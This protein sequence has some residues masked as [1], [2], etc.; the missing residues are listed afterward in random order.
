[1]AM[2]TIA[3]PMG[4]TLSRL[5]LLIKRP[6]WG[7]I[8][9]ILRLVFL[10][11]GAFFGF[12]TARILLW[13]VHSVEEF[14]VDHYL[15]VGA[16][17][18]AITSSVFFGPVLR[19]GKW[20]SGAGLA[21]AW[22]FT[23]V[24]CLSGSVGRSDELANERNA[25]A[26]Q[27]NRDRDRA[28]RNRDEAKQRYDTALAAET[29]DCSGGAGPKCIGK[30]AVTQD[31]RTDYEVSETLLQHV[32]PEQRENGRLKRL[33]QVISICSRLDEAE[34]E[35]RLVIIWP[36]LPP[37]SCELLT[38]VFMHL[39]LTFGHSRRPKAQFSAPL[40]VAG[41][42]AD[43]VQATPIEAAQVLKEWKPMSVMRARELAKQAQAEA[44]FEALRQRSPVCND[45]LAK[46]LNINK[47]ECSRRV[48]ALHDVGLINRQRS[49]R[50]V[51]ITLRPLLTV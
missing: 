38:M 31:R 22:V 3:R 8:G 32:K 20:L 2:T 50:Y 35:R 23:T 14:T 15:T 45:E 37:L 43:T 47:G 4:A 39:G 36:F 24:I 25:I 46:H 21:I 30:R 1:M 9:L 49:G 41:T 44:V 40:P 5:R 13:E 12:L 28:Q 26:R 51:A 17:V 16:F 11:L 18:G 34:A 27:I 33:A 48:S 29:A 6:D 10:G 19:R 7:Q 42:V